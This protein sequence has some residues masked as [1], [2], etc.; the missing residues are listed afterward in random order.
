MYTP[1]TLT[2]FINNASAGFCT[3]LLL[4]SNNP[5]LDTSDD[6]VG[7]V[8]VPFSLT[9]SPRCFNAC[10]TSFCASGNIATSLAANFVTFDAFNNWSCTVLP[11][12]IFF[13]PCIVKNLP[14]YR[15]LISLTSLSAYCLYSFSFSRSAFSLPCISETTSSLAS[16][17]NAVSSSSSIV[18]WSL[19]SCF[20]SALCSTLSPNINAEYSFSSYSN[21]IPSSPVYSISYTSSVGI[22][23][24]PTSSTLPSYKSAFMSSSISSLAVDQSNSS[25]GLSSYFNSSWRFSS[26]SC[27]AVNSA[28]SCAD[29]VFAS[30]ISLCCTVIIRFISIAAWSSSVCI[31]FAL[32]RSL[33]TCALVFRDLTSFGCA[34]LSSRRSN[35]A[36]L[37]AVCASSSAIYF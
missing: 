9:F 23:T 32:S 18:L 11:S 28:I 20:T 33:C 26:S 16:L 31:L 24:S 22:S 37:A 15:L 6:A 3:I 2:G 36:V 7:S 27:S 35:R 17:A 4:A 8:T 25:I 29:N 12:T 13:N 10:V 1:S 14:P 34:A 21:D 30:S 19:T 5:L